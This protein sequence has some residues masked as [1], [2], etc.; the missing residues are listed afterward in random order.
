[1]STE[2][3]KKKAPLLLVN[4]EPAVNAPVTSSKTLLFQLSWLP[5]SECNLSK[6]MNRFP[7]FDDA[8][9]LFGF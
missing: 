8:H 7:L 4:N 1:M 3:P 9:F 2:S 5:T 6:V